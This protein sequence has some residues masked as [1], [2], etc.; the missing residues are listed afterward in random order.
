MRINFLYKG[1]LV[2]ATLCVAP[3]TLPASRGAS[4]PG[5][6]TAGSRQGA[7]ANHASNLLQQIQADALRVKVRADRL[8]ALTDEPWVVD[9]HAFGE[10]LQSVHDRV[11]EMDKLLSQL[12]ANQSEALPWQQQ[13]I[14]RIAPTVVNLT[15]TTQA[16]IVSLNENQDVYYSDLRG[17]AGDMCNQ[18]RRIEQAIANF[19][20][21]ANARHEAPQLKQTLGPKNNS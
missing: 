3:A 11:N 7:F 4:Q 19:E 10:Q 5:V 17:L 8:Q 13:A 14:N 6:R 12:R 1:V 21:Y 2:A 18:A 15:D 9:W 16:A 20:K